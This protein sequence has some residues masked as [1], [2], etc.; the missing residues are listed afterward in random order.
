M[1]MYIGLIVLIT[2]GC[3]LFK[4]RVTTTGKSMAAVRSKTQ[5]KL[6]ESLDMKIQDKKLQ[7]TNNYFI[8]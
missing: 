2:A 5:S 6:A 8:K 4:N 3:G 1:R 7:T